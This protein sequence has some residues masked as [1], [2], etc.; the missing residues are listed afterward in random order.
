V[1]FDA[2]GQEVLRLEAYFRP[3]HVAG[4]LE[5][6]SSGAYRSEP[7]FQRFLQSKAERMRRGGER[8]ILWN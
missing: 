8:S 3:F 6:V 5:Y 7:S 4:S 1:L 2:N